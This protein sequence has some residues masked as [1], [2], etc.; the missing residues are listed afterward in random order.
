MVY[1]KCRFEFS[2]N[3]HLIQNSLNFS[4]EVKNQEKHDN[5]EQ[6]ILH[7]CETCGLTF[8]SSKLLKKHIRCHVIAPIT[9][10]ECKIC[11]K[12]F[13]SEALLRAHS[14]T[15]SN[16]RPYICEVHNYIIEK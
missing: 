3:E 8:D 11:S 7:Q 14:R 10:R 5:D 16:L 6:V 9:S 15:H 13:K 2:C 12:V 4:W 1:S